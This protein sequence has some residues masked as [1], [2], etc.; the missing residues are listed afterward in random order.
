M[1]EKPRKEIL[2]Q[3]EFPILIFGEGSIACISLSVEYEDEGIKWMELTIEPSELLKK[4]Y[5]I[6]DSELD[7]NKC[8]TI[9]IKR[10]DVILLNPFSASN[11][12]WLYTKNFMG[13][14]TEVSNLGWD[15]RRRLEESE[16]KRRILE[17]E[18]TWYSEQ[19]LLAKTNP[20]EFA[21]QP[22]EIFEKITASTIEAFKTKER[23]ED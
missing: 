20:I 17:G 6:K 19:L 7:E 11:N 3:P 5:N 9:K 14:D 4:K 12:K 2:I 13:E 8:V 18:T 1:G 15:L 16:K 21:S 10:D 23:K 22:L